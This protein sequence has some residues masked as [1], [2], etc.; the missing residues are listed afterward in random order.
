MK[1]DDNNILRFYD[2]GTVLLEVDYGATDVEQ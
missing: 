1:M 2:Q